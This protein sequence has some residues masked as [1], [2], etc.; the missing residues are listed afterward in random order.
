MPHCPPQFTPMYQ[1]TVT[2][3][4]IAALIISSVCKDIG[5]SR[6]IYFVKSEGGTNE[7][8]T[9]LYNDRLRNLCTLVKSETMN[10]CACGCVFKLVCKLFRVSGLENRSVNVIHKHKY[11]SEA[12][13]LVKCPSTEYLFKH[14][15]S[16]LSTDT[17][18]C[19][20]RSSTHMCNRALRLNTDSKPKLD[21]ILRQFILLLGLL[22]LFHREFTENLCSSVPPP[23][24]IWTSIENYFHTRNWY[25]FAVLNVLWL[26]R[27][28]PF[29]LS[30]CPVLSVTA[31]TLYCTILPLSF[32][33]I[34]R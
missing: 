20:R 15:Y 4:H 32:C 6:V 16:N 10:I 29:P 33:V 34:L 13:A 30:R 23:Q 2:F 22:S 11:A 28:D 18:F 14:P 26:W 21:N 17:Q 12:Q 27:L 5:V 1:E 8:F 24:R 7:R 31:Y 9:T 25:L 3:I 19:F